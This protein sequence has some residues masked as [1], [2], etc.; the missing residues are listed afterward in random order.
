MKP[1]VVIPTYDEAGN[2]AELLRRV[3]HAAPGADILVVDDGSPDGTADV[4]R[5]CAAELGRIEVCVRPGKL[6]L[7]SAY[8]EAFA[9]GLRRGY[10]VLVQMDGDLSH[11]PTALPALLRAVHAG[12]DLAVGSRYVPGGSI[13]RWS[14]FRRALSR[15]GNRYARAM[16]ALPLADATSGFR[17]YRA[18]A[19]ARLDLASVRAEGYGFQI[20]LT[21]RMARAG[22]RIAEVPIAFADRERGR[23]KMSGR[24]IAEALLLVTGW[25][26]RDLTGAPWR[27]APSPLDVR[28]RRAA[29]RSRRRTPSAS[30]SRTTS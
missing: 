18:G 15:W 19:L 27:P 16:L 3:R 21:Y 13:P 9:R 1:L 11:D 24:I 8:R 14:A 20:E 7:G 26:L 28:R 29:R 22:G 25:A 6:G 5:A 4:A 17:A 12:A 10:R 23:S 30:W 2:I